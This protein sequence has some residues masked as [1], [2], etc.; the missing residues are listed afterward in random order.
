MLETVREFVAERLA[1]QADVAQAGRRHADYYRA[2]ATQADRPMRGVGHSQWL[3]R[4]QAEAGNL[5]AAVEWYLAHDTGPL[6]HLFRVLWLFWE[7]R[8]RMGEAR[9]WV[10]RLLPAAD[11]LDPQARCE[12]LWTAA[13]TATEVG[14]DGAALA[15]RQRL[16]PLLAEI[17]DPHLQAVSQLAM[18]WSSPIV[19]DFDGALREAS[20]SLEQLR[21]QEEP[22][23]TAVTGLSAGYLETSVGRL[24]DALRHLREAHDLAERFHYDW[25]AAWSRVQLG[26]LAITGSRL[27]EARTLLDE[28]LELSLAVRSTRNVG[29]YLP[30]FAQLALV[31]GDA[32]RAALLVGAAEGL[33]QRVG[34]RAWPMLRPG[35]AELV[36]QIREAL[37]ADRFEEL[38]AAGA[39]LNR[40]EAVAALRDRGGAG[41]STMV[42][43]Q[44]GD[45]AAARR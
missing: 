43:M 5:A 11:S 20:V 40:R 6:P 3:E 18:A 41:A 22:Y 26:T 33:R 38:F 19:G 45:A 34:L 12:L 4:L 7:L 42:V 37:G 27:E 1:S 15:A 10:E 36:A 25:L 8:D 29:L 30:A 28:G 21:G 24:D 39:R 16:A 32:E 2:L 31:E 17:D 14:D 9:A 35:E 23:W 44:P 13:V